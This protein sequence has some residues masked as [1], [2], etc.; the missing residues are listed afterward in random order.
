MDVEECTS[1]LTFIQ[2]SDAMA[3]NLRLNE[4]ISEH[5]LESIKTLLKDINVNIEVHEEGCQIHIAFHNEEPHALRTSLEPLVTVMGDEDFPHFMPLREKIEE[6]NI[7]LPSTVLQEDIAFVDTPG[8][9]SVSQTRQEITY[10]IIERSHLV[11]CFVDSSFAGNIHDLNFIKRI[12]KWRGRRVFFVL[13]K[14]DKLDPDEIDMRGIRGPASSLLEAFG[15]HDIPED[16][17]IF[18]LSGYRALRAQQLDNGQIT[19]EEVLD[20]NKISIPLGIQK[21]LEESTHPNA[22]LA[23]Y[24]MGQSRFPHLKERLLDYLLNENKAGAVVGTAGRFVWERADDFMAPLENEL[25]LA[26]D[27]TKFDELRANRENLLQKLE[28]IR[29]NSDQVLN[30]Y[31]ARSKGGQLDGVVC[32]GY[33]AQF[34]SKVNEDTIQEKVIAPLI[35][36]LREGNNLKDARRKK[37]ES[38]STQMEHQ[39]DEFISTIMQGLTATMEQA[40]QEA[41]DDITEHLG[42]VRGLRTHMTDPGQVEISVIESSVAGS[43]M[44]FGAGG[45]ALGAAAGAAVGSFVPGLGTAIGAGVGGLMGIA[46]GFLTRLA[47]SEDRWL[48][49]L[50]PAIQENA[51]NMIIHGVKDKEGYRGKPIIESVA[52]H[53]R[54]RADVFYEAVQGEVDNAIDVVQKECDGLLAREEEIRRESN[55]IIERLEPKVTQLSALRSQAQTIVEETT[56]V[57]KVTL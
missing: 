37:F 52:E 8:V 36:W 22:D 38:L 10:G 15:R 55:A 17:E 34:R 35:A 20:D 19:L 23:A 28:E 25:E 51:L 50:E 40:E 12:I 3:L 5:E 32:T 24:L 49:K 1:K 47:W 45:A 26:K 33:E 18:F 31:N 29:A 11:I 16:S 46:T 7:Q 41:R 13:N 21:R 43:Y 48:K 2:R 27:P 6:L 53:L 30:R 56:R 9:H 4:A 14:A 54:T 57:D 44:A 39:V 42:Q